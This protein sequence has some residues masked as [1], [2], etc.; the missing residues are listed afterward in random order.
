[1]RETSKCHD[2]RLARG[3]FQNYLRGDGIDIGAGDDA[4]RVPSGTVRPWD[5]PDGDAQLLAGISADCFD[6]V[7]SSHCLEHMRG[8]PEAL[9]NWIRVLRPGGWLYVVVPDYLL[10]EK[11]TWPSPFNSDHPTEKHTFVELLTDFP[12]RLPDL[13]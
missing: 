1:M 5:Q 7:Y 12:R 10:Y 2:M 11:M 8:V 4:L 13:D 6:F 9:E 3:D